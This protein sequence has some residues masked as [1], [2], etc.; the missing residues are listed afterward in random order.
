[1]PSGT[2]QK[3]KRNNSA[4]YIQN[5]AKTISRIAHLFF[6]DTQRPE[7]DTL[8]EF[9][10][11]QQDAAGCVYHHLHTDRAGRCIRLLQRAHGGV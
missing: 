8:D 7:H 3:G 10:D 11:Q 4:I 9:G 6:T 5:P 1:M 2:N